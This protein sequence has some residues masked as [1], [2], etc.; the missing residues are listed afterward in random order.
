M[1]YFLWS[2]AHGEVGSS[3]RGPVTHPPQGFFL[4]CWGLWLR[5]WAHTVPLGTAVPPL[6]RT[7]QARAGSGV[8]E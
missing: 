5:V 8:T 2:W 6:S 1:G 4:R 3:M 7:G